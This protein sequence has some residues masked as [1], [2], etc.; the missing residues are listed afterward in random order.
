[1]SKYTTENPYNLT[2][3][4]LSFCE[5][6]IFHEDLRGNGTQSAIKAGYSAK[7]A[8]RIADQNLKKLDIQKHIVFLEMKFKK[9]LEK[10]TPAD[11]A[12][13]LDLIVSKKYGM[14]YSSVNMVAALELKLRLERKIAGRGVTITNP[15]D[16]DNP[17]EISSE[18]QLVMIMPNERPLVIRENE[19]QTKPVDKPPEKKN[20]VKDL[21]IQAVNNN[22][23]GVKS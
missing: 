23:K 10:R 4:Q 7:T 5:Y 17:V 18:T 9:E 14:E 8:G 3:K 22:K 16:P 1:M 2:T 21:L 19:E 6:Y 11:A 15:N 20:L 13:I 12:A